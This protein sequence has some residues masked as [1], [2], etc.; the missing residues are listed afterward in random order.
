MLHRFARLH[1][2]LIRFKRTWW[3]LQ[4][5]RNTAKGR[6]RDIAAQQ[7]YHSQA[8]NELLRDLKETKDSLREE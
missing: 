6:E 4:H 2:R 7:R 3:W 1:K 8:V 5:W